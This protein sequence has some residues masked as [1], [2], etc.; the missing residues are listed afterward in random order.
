MLR[1]VMFT[2]TTTTSIA[3]SEWAAVAAVAVQSDT[4]SGFV[5]AP[6]FLE[7]DGPAGQTWREVC[8]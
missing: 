4:G 8:V 5:V 7:E 1:R 3:T 6:E 2:N